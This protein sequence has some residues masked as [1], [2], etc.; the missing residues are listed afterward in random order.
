MVSRRYTDAEIAQI[1][2]DAAVAGYREGEQRGVELVKQ[3]GRVMAEARKLIDLIDLK[4]PVAGVTVSFAL[5][6]RIIGGLRSPGTCTRLAGELQAILDDANARY[7][8][9]LEEAEDE[10]AE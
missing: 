6:E 2:R 3:S 7:A 4:Y 8:W 9:T 10:I 1:K 5:A